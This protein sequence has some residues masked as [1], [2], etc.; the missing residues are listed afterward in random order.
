MVAL[1]SQFGCKML[2][3]MELIEA[4]CL[5]AKIVHQMKQIV[6]LM[7]YLELLAV[8]SLVL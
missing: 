3:V 4:V 7:M 5:A 1:I 6:L 8:S 2:I